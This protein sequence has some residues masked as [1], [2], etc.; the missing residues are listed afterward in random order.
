MHAFYSMSKSSVQSCDF[1][2]YKFWLLRVVMAK[3]QSVKSLQV[4]LQVL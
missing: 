3:L 2:M 4:D 1:S